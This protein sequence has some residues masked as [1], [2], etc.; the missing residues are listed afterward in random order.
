M[1]LAGSHNTLDFE[2]G[3][4]AT[5]DWYKQNESWWKAQKEETENKYKETEK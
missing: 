2:Q 3:L 4:K 1:N 5:I